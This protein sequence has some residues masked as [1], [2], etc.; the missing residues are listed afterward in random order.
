[1]T[2][3]RGIGLLAILTLPTCSGVERWGIEEISLKGPSTG[4]PY[5]DVQL[6]A[7]FRFRNRE[8][9]AEGFYDGGGDYRIRFMPDEVGDWTYSTYS[10]LVSLS[11]KSGKF[12]ATAAT[13]GNRGPVR[14]RY[15]THFGYEDGAPYVPVGTTA[16]AWIHQGDELEEQ[17]LRTLKDSPFN[18][19][20]MCIFPKHYAH[21]SNEPVYYPFPRTAAG[22]NDYSRF[23]PDFFQ[24]LERRVMDLQKLGIEADLILFHPYDNWGYSKMPAEVDDRYLH[25]VVARL[26]AYRNV[27]WSMANEYDFMKNKT[28]ADW[29]R[30]FR[31]VSDSDPYGHLRSIHNGGPMYDHSKGWVTHVSVQSSDLE[32]GLAWIKE[33]RKPVIFDE[34]KYEGNISQ[35]WGNLP[36]Q[37]MV[38]RFWLATVQGA[39]AGHGETYEDAKDVLWWSKG[40]VLKGESPRR[41]AFLRKILE[42]APKEGLDN[43]S[44][45]YLGAG[46]PGRYYLFYFD[47]NE[48]AEYSFELAKGA[49]FRAEW[50]DPWE[51]TVQPV[52]GTF[53]GRF[54][55]KLP[56]RPFM[57]VRFRAEH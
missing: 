25:Y 50:I 24:H 42:D 44:T 22:E 23:N 45:Y 21:N 18:K 27:W 28:M 5:L 38:R 33:Y 15:T 52:P 54:T 20:R 11:G 30:Y 57:A 26:A 43:L 2:V 48:P 51:M 40:G 16:Y 1:M 10:N 36:A 47:V 12:T 19:I 41:I 4:N 7:H 35:R 56:G 31:I 9:D 49:R 29:D 6:G 14:V 34:C 3:I 37:E 39:Y 46:Q 13:A 8:V 53:E 32:K 55:M 17:T